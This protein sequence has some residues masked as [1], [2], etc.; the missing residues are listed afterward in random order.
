MQGR[1]QSIIRR[2]KAGRQLSEKKDVRIRLFP[3]DHQKLNDLG[4][5][6]WVEEKIGLE[7]ACLSM[8]VDTSRFTEQMKQEFLFGWKKAGG[9][10]TDKKSEKPI[11]EP[12]KQNLIIE[13]KAKTLRSMGAEYWL[14]IRDAMN[15][16]TQEQEPKS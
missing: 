14:Q 7:D 4:G 12:W 2:N 9:F 11:S 15:N 5:S 1:K 3:E 6:V 8:R 13:T 10:V 16:L